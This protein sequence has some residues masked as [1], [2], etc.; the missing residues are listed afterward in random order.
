M[1]S[2]IPL[3]GVLDPHRVRPP[4]HDRVHRV[5]GVRGRVGGLGQAGVVRGHQSLHV[6]A[7]VVPQVPPV[8]DLH[9]AGRTVT[10]AVGVPA[11]PVPADHLHA[12]VG[13]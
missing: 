5:H 7:Q 4:R 13:A 8:G 2:V 12:G 11:G 6:L 3:P 10:G 9:R 1:G